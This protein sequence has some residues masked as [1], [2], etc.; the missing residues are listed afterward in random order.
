MG[1]GTAARLVGSWR[2]VETWREEAASGRREAQFGPAPSGWIVYTPEGRM[3]ALITG[4]ARHPPRDAADRAALHASMLAYS[5]RYTA[6]ADR[7]EH[8]IDVAWQP[9]VVGQTFIRFVRFEGERLVLTSPPGPSAVDGV[10]ATVTVV[11]E[12]DA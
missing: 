4:S 1:E 7:V 5:G 9:A 10:V 11:W 2:L 12:R 3:M 6:F 8:R